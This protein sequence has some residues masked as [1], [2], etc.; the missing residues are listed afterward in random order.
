MYG[1]QTVQELIVQDVICSLGV[2]IEHLFDI[3][4]FSNWE[5]ARGVQ[6]SN[7]EQLQILHEHSRDFLVDENSCGH[8]VVM[9]SIYKEGGALDL[10]NLLHHS[11]ICKAS[12]VR[13]HIY[14]FLNI[15]RNDFGVCVNYDQSNTVEDLF[16]EVT[17]KAI[18]CHQEIS[19]LHCKE[20]ADFDK[21]PTQLPSWVNTPLTNY[22][23]WLT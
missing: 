14:A 6:H 15:S 19:I 13:D 16:T 9:R 11:R 21:R 5:H 18:K 4:E 23:S 8:V 2:N 7:Q 1:G 20:V 17:R 3:E 22:T 10:A 12:D